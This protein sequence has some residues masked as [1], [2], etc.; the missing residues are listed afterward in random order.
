MK[1]VEKLRSRE[2]EE[3]RRRESSVKEQR[4]LG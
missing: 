2:V 1:I 3:Y 4:V